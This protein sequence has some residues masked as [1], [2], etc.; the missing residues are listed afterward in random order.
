MTLCGL[1][2]P[3]TGNLFNALKRL[4]LSDKPRHLWVDAL[5]INQQDLDERAQQVMMM[6]DIFE[7][8]CRT[9]LWVGEE[10]ETV[11]GATTFHI[12]R[13]FLNR[14]I[15]FQELLKKHREL[16]RQKFG[17]AK[18]FWE[19]V[20][21]FRAEMALF[22]WQ[23]WSAGF[24]SA[25]N[26]SA[27]GLS[28]QSFSMRPGDTIHPNNSISHVNHFMSKV[29]SA[30]DT[31][32]SRRY[33]YRMWI[34]Q[35]LSKSRN[36]E[37]RCGE[38]TLPWSVLQAW[39][40]SMDQMKGYIGL[41]ERPGLILAVL[42]K[43]RDDFAYEKFEN[44]DSRKRLLHY[45]AITRNVACEDPR[46]A[47]YA[48]LGLVPGVDIRANYKISIKTLGT[49]LSQRPCSIRGDWLSTLPRFGIPDKTKAPFRSAIM[50]PRFSRNTFPIW[51]IT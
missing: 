7:Q 11:D 6:G 29:Q 34:I 30:M 51:S 28:L 31:F 2:V 43:S 25:Q 16:L 5:C 8:N 4:R 42:S 40:L 48:L 35:E 21:M 9:Q 36:A 33:F 19:E 15:A 32:H 17:I 1:C 12:C 22:L 13:I 26:P 44:I 27:N 47:I 41:E 10:S 3:I 23:N 24:G 38:D 39:E 18:E 50:G 49:E 20:R 37:V 45:M 14:R 46:D